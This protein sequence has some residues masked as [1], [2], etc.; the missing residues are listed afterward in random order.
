MKTYLYLSTGI[1][2]LAV[3]IYTGTGLAQQRTAKPAAAGDAKRGEYLVVE[4]AKCQECHT[5]RDANGNLDRERWMQGA[6]IWITP[7][8]PRSDWAENAPILAGF[9][10]YSDQDAIN[11][12]ERGMGSDGQ[13]IRPPM[14]VYHMNH[15]DTLDIVAYLRSLPVAAR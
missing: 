3:A 7:V 12:F 10:G 15:Q 2:F 4:V 1:L 6:P 11:I 13:A 14:H 9:P 5:P 8:H